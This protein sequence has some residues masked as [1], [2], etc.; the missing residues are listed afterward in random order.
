MWWAEDTFQME[1]ISRLKRIQRLKCPLRFKSM[2]G[3]RTKESR[4]GAIPRR[5]RAHGDTIV[6]DGLLASIDRFAPSERKWDQKWLASTEDSQRDYKGED[7][8]IP[9][10]KTQ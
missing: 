8:S 6:I 9:N 7:P 3:S 5:L 2:T 10:I 1:I 4:L